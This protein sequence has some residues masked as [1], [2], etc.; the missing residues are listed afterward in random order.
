MGRY[1]I[2]IVDDEQEVRQAMIRKLDWEAL[3]FQV[4]LEAEN[5]Q[6][7]LE[8]AESVPLDVVLTD[9]KM[10]FMDGFTMGKHLMRTHPGVKLII[11]SGFDE[12]QY[13]KEAIKLNVVEYILK[14]VNAQE[15]TQIFT[16]V[17]ESLD[18]EIAQRRNIARLTAAYE[19]SL[20]LLREQYLNA[21]IGGNLTR[22]EAEVGAARFEPAFRDDPYHAVV[23]FHMETH[24]TD[25]PAVA[26]ELLPVSLQQLV[27]DRLLGLCHLE[28]IL[29]P[30]NLIAITGWSADPSESLIG[31]AEELC[32]QVLRALGTTVTVGVG[33]AC[34]NFMELSGSRRDSLA[35]VEYK[36]IAGEGR[37]YY[38]G[39][40]QS[41]EWEPFDWDRRRE[42]RFLFA[43]K[44][45][46]QEQIDAALEELMSRLDGLQP[47]DWSYAA[48][49]AGIAGFVF[50]T[51]QRYETETPRDG[52]LWSRLLDR[53]CP[54]EKAKEML[55]NLSLQIRAS[56]AQRRNSG[57]KNLA[58][59]AKQYI[60]ANYQNP[61]L[62][63]ETICSELHISQSYF[64]NLFK[65]ETGKSCIQY[66][67]SVRMDRAVELLRTTDDRT[68]LV[69][70][71]VGYDDANYF[72]YVFKKQFGI[73]PTQ[74]RK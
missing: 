50:R 20:P 2:M 21:L 60:Q 42:E 70:Q 59:A 61:D 38:Y 14:P 11:F 39:D 3:G 64:S 8:K 17:R 72:S 65:Q 24:P 68:Y 56:L 45:G 74:F 53:N 36:A 54:L 40:L 7:A 30:P 62:S 28:T 29:N 52:I 47:G 31:L 6:D 25:Q 73:S 35:A 41:V 23:M 15:L 10:P 13:A 51:A 9:I 1:R 37:A 71:K 12:F 63:V 19:Q 55:L 34:R 44:Y 66:L 46:T 43:I 5:G 18:E 33:R 4:V 22:E 69:A 32:A 27:T 26:A 48:G 58:E 67:T 57:A 16:R 49:L